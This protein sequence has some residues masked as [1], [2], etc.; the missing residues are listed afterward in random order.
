MASVT[1]GNT[2][3]IR[4]V[5]KLED[6][7]VFDSTDGGAALEFKV[8][9]GEFLAG[10]EQGVIG[11]DAGETKTIRIAAENAYGLR[12]EERVFDYEKKKLPE[13]LNPEVGQSLQMYRA[14]G[15]PVTVTIVGVSEDSVKLDCNH[16]LA[17]KNLIFDVTLEEIL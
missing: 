16:H 9:D 2:V 7:T 1:V 8:G 10:L 6:G 13:N 11:M 15:M 12:K 14:D 17:G 5:G 3:R 4:Y